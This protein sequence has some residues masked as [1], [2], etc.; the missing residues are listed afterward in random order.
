[1][2]DGNAKQ[3]RSDVSTITM[4]KPIHKMSAVAW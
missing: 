1:V 4:T 3:A 2:A